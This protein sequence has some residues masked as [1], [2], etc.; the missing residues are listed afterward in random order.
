MDTLILV[1]CLAVAAVIAVAAVRFYTVHKHMHTAV[2]APHHRHHLMGIASESDELYIP[3]DSD[4]AS[5]EGPATDDF[6]SRY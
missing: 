2:A 3:G 5:D 4:I 1:L 6:G